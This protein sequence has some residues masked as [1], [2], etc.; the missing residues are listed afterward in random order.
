[1]TERIEELINELE[2]EIYRAKRAAFSQ[3]EV[4]VDR[5]AFLS[6]IERIR[7]NMPPV[8]SE[9]RR[10]VDDA[11]RIR[12]DALNYAE[13]TAAKAEEYAEK[14]IDESEILQKAGEEA[15]KIKAE[16]LEFCEEKEREAVYNIDK[17]LSQSEEYL[18]RAVLVLRDNRDTLRNRK[19]RPE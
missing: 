8:L 14:M 11:A 4:L 13:D 6:L 18:T 19:K 2:A 17:L 3:T 7:A 9:A 15:Q 12:Q 1:M 10:I 16:A 5:R